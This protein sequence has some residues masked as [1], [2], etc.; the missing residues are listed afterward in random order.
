MDIQLTSVDWISITNPVCDMKPQALIE[1]K[2][3]PQSWPSALAHY[4]RKLDVPG[5]LVYPE[6]PIQRHARL[7]W[8]A[9]SGGFLRGLL[10][11]LPAEAVSAAGRTSPV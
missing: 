10:L 11:D 3:S 9:P 6:G 8:K 4:C 5:F 2:L 7:G 1:T